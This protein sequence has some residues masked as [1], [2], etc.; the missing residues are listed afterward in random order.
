MP[1]RSG[2]QLSAI[3]GV[4]PPTVRSVDP[5]G[6]SSWLGGKIDASHEPLLNVANE[7]NR[8]AQFPIQIEGAALQELEVSGVFDATDVETFLRF[9]EGIQGVQVERNS[10]AVEVRLR[11]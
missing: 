6:V 9:L 11:R 2:Q 4:W 3:Y 10:T 1:L 7:F 8:Y 5:R